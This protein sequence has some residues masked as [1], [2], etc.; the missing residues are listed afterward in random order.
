MEIPDIQEARMSQTTV[1]GS[2]SNQ[3]GK[4]GA[5]RFLI[6]GLLFFSYFV[7]GLSWI[8]YSPFL[9]DFQTQFGL[10]HASAGLV[11]SSVSF[12]KIF[13]PF[14]ADT[15]AQIRDQSHSFIRYALHLR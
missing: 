13:V 9:H 12:A 7:F 14:V 5:Y 11:I 15:G 2:I 10:T 3:V 1:L 8:G 6:E 4:T